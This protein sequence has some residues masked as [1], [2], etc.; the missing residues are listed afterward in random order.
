M[1]VDTESSSP[2]PIPTITPAPTLE[3]VPPAETSVAPRVEKSDAK[4]ELMSVK[5]ASSGAADTLTFAFA[6][7]AVPGYDIRYVDKLLRSDDDVVLLDGSA[8]LTVSFTNSVPG[9]NG[10]IPK[11]VITNE[12]YDL[13]AIRQVLLATNLGGALVFGVGTAAQTPF[14]VAVQ[15]NSLTVSFPR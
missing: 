2:A 11:K 7:R 4:G 8:V 14:T 1:T 9:K 6:D 15:G 5:V 3:P 13:P 12:T 10:T